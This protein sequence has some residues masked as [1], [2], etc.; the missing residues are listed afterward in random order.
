MKYLYLK[1]ITKLFEDGIQVILI[2]GMQA[3]IQ[4]CVRIALA[5][6]DQ[7][8]GITYRIRTSSQHVDEGKIRSAIH[9]ELQKQ[10][11]I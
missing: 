4:K 10:L 9:I 8:C 5:I 1:R 3:S 7:Y 6:Q 11:I 2:H